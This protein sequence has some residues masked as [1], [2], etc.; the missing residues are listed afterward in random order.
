[1]ATQSLLGWITDHDN[2]GWWRGAAS[3]VV[4]VG[5]LALPVT[6]HKER[7]KCNVLFVCLQDDGLNDRLGDM[8]S[9]GQGRGCMHRQGRGHSPK[10]V[11]LQ[12]QD[13]DDQNGVFL[14]IRPQN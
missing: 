10:C 12:I 13:A 9:I 6:G 3:M 7:R 14:S 11:L 1:M 4:V 5:W 8:I 2:M